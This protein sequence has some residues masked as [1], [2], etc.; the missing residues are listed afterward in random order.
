M[1]KLPDNYIIVMENSKAVLAHNERKQEYVAWTKDAT[2]GVC[3]G[4][5]FSY[6]EFFDMKQEQALRLAIAAYEKK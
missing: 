1:I 5:Y 4:H 3:W 6:N 2:N